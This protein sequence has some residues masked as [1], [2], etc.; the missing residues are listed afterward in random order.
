MLSSLLLG[1]RGLQ[2]TGV[3]ARVS[4]WYI[5]GEVFLGLGLELGLGLGLG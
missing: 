5:C 3:S 1:Q 2:T 4:V